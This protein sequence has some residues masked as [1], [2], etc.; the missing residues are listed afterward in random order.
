MDHPVNNKPLAVCDPASV[1]PESYLTY[2][3]RYPERTG[4]TYAMDSKD[5]KIK[6]HDWYYYPQMKK[7]EALMFYVFDKKESSPGF[8]MHTGFDHPDTPKDADDRVSL[9]CRSIAIFDDEPDTEI[10]KKAFFF[11]MKHSNNAARIRLWLKLKG[12]DHMVD[13]K[14][15]TYADL[16]SEEFKKVNPLKKVPAFTTAEGHAVFES[17]VIME[18]LEDKYGHLGPDMRLDTPEERAFVQLIVRNHD[19][20]I[21]SPNCTQ[22]NFCHSQGAM[23]LAPFVTPHCAPERVL[24]T[25][26]RAAKIAE[27]FK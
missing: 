6:N 2:E 9:E 25:P 23:Y 22:P 12:L 4:E 19:L 26:T 11:D 20:Y 8:V 5:P 3:L 15:V 7:E 21:A 1:D 10:E 24:D 13:S 16:Q 27:I 17:Y 14:M 18:Y